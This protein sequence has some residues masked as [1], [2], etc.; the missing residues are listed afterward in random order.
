MM[1]IPF[2][3]KENLWGFARLGLAF[4]I[5][6]LVFALIKFND[7]KIYKEITIGFIRGFFQ[8]MLMTVVIVFAFRYPNPF[9]IGLLVMVM[10]FMGGYTA[11]KRVEKIPNA[12]GIILF[13]LT[14]STFVGLVWIFLTYLPISVEYIIPMAG[15]AAGNG[16]N[17]I[18]IVLERFTSQLKDNRDK[19]ETY[20]AL[21][22][23]TQQATKELSQK[24]IK[25]G[26]M[27]TMNSIKTLGVV[28][29]PGAMVGL[30]MA[31]EDPVIAFQIQILVYLLIFTVGILSST[32][33]LILVTRKLFTRAHQLS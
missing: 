17:I 31:G 16:M 9:F 3:T 4:L 8:L 27:P 1:D 20:L 22:A 32:I 15:L 24:A 14:I 25:V 33:A 13:S 11:Y 2:L 10:I 26:L 7:L 19:I 29:I 30:L 12:F 23:T 21:G 5:L 28:F 6:I 18:S